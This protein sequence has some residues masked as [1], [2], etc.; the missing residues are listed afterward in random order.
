M[1]QTFRTSGGLLHGPAGGARALPKNQLGRGA[2]RALDP[3]GRRV[4]RGGQVRR[5]GAQARGVRLEQV[6]VGV[7]EARFWLEIMLSASRRGVAIEA[8]FE[9]LIALPMMS[10]DQL[11][12]WTDDLLDI[13]NYV[14]V[15]R[16][17]ESAR[18]PE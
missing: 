6:Q 10:P 2:E 17:P 13:G 15:I 4:G 16:L 7:Q 14:E 8:V 5:S 18:P 12:G 3:H 1:E 9:A 11:Q